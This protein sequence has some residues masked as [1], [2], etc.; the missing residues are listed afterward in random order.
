MAAN[1]EAVNRLLDDRE[2]QGLERT[3]T[4]PAALRQVARLVVC[5]PARPKAG[6][7]AD[8]PPPPANQGRGHQTIEP[9]PPGSTIA[10]TS[11]HRVEAGRHGRS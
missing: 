2:R 7:T 4:D 11:L 9:E 3:V 10:V 1:Q 8:A 5:C 6:L